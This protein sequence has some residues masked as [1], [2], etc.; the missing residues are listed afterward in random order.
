[1]LVELKTKINFAISVALVALAGM[2]W[3]SLRENQN[4]T[5]AGRWVSHTHEVLETSASL[6][7]HL[8]EAGIARRM[9][10]QGDSKQVDAFTVAA[11]ASITDFNAL[12]SLTRDNP[13][14]QKRLDRLE[15]LVHSRLA[16]L[17]KSIDAHILAAN[18][19]SF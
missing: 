12:R 2:G 7:S 8:S 10:L 1:M 3:L 19:E 14:Q 17:S 6:R 18:D 4:L 5:E 13:E 9:F 16:V 11:N 15:P